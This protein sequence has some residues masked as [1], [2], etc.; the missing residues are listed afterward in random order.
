LRRLARISSLSLLAALSLGVSAAH[1]AYPGQDGR[2]TSQGHFGQITAVERD[3][4]GV[5]GVAGPGYGWGDMVFR[6]QAVA[7]DGQ[8]LIFAATETCDRWCDSWQET[9]LG[10]AS[11]DGGAPAAIWSDTKTTPVREMENPSW[12]P[13]GKE[14]VTAGRT[15]EG[16]RG[17][18]V[19]PVNGSDP[20]R[21]AL[22]ASL[23]TPDFPAFS[24]DGTRIAF[25]AGGEGADA[26]IYVI[27]VAGGT[28][29]NLGPGYG[30]S[31]SPDG[32]RL[33]HVLVDPDGHGRL[34]ARPVDGGALDI[35][36]NDGTA[37]V[38]GRP[39]WSPSVTTWASASRASTAPSSSAAAR[40]AGSS[41]TTRRSVAARSA[42]RPARPS[43]STGRGARSGG[44]PAS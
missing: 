17:L 18:F 41:T 27:P 33:A 26:R 2:L 43:R 34:A 32:T 38:S 16:E 9:A 19:I 37:D 35:M 12:S 29:V 20:R 24:P 22:P 21:I 8:R 25:S 39:A 40:S 15:K 5:R 4:S 14:I 23:G 13:D 42:R 6:G 3:G 30:P 31:W 44:R 10:V 11:L 28:P 36:F 7:P 1:A